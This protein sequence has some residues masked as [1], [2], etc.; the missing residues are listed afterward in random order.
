MDYQQFGE[1]SP[2]L[3]KFTAN[4]DSLKRDQARRIETASPARP[5][6]VGRR[7]ATMPYQQALFTCS[8][9]Q[10]MCSGLQRAEVV[11]TG[12]IQ[13]DFPIKTFHQYKL[14]LCNQTLVAKHFF[15]KTQE[16]QPV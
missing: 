13:E 15:K 10:Q 1:L 2:A 16:F 5:A 7:Q 4:R 12:H 11:S 14:G 8:K 3:D 6:L 9:W